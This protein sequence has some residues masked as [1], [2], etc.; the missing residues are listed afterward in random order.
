MLL[1]PQGS[2]RQ[3]EGQGGERADGSLACPVPTSNY[4]PKSWSLGSSPLLLLLIFK[5]LPRRK[6]S[7]A[8][9]GWPSFHREESYLT[10]MFICPKPP[11]SLTNGPPIPS[12][13]RGKYTSGALA[14][15][16][17]L[18]GSLHVGSPKASMG[19]VT[20]AGPR[21]PAGLTHIIESGN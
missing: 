5:S 3:A 1:F 12:G 11:M 9:H 10:W 14:K 4:Q 15:E 20:F 13:F 6:L 7:R 17:P 19:W 8:H 18:W 16:G 21:S 2:T